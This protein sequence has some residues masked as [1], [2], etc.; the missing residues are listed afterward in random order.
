MRHEN[1]SMLAERGLKKREK[2]TYKVPPAC[3]GALHVIPGLDF[4][5]L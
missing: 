1:R 2:G 4:A 3:V 5:I